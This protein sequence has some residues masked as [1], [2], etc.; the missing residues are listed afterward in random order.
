MLEG[1]QL[2]AL[3][4]MLGVASCLT[5]IDALV[6]EDLVLKKENQTIDRPESNTQKEKKIPLTSN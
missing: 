3:R 4:W 5:D 6:V 2:F 1:S